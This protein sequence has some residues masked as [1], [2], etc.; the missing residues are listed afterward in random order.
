M[1]DE[2]TTHLISTDAEL[3]KQSLKIKQA[4][5]NKIPIVS[6]DWLLQSLEKV[7]QQPESDYP[8]SAADASQAGPSQGEKRAAHPDAKDDDQEPEPA[9]KKA[10]AVDGTARPKRGAKKEPEPVKDG[11]AKKDEKKDDKDEKGDEENADKDEEEEEKPAAKKKKKA[12]PAKG[13]AKAKKQTKKDEDEQ[14]N[15]DQEEKEAED[16]PVMK[17][18]IKK[19]KAPV[20]VLSGLSCKLSIHR[21]P[22][23]TAHSTTLQPPIT[24]MSMTRARPGMQPSTRPMLVIP[25]L[26]TRLS[27]GPPLI[28]LDWG[29]QQQVLS[30]PVVGERRQVCQRLCCVCPLGSGWRKWPEPVQNVC[31]PMQL[32][33][34]PLQWC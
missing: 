29:Q 6:I 17:T 28:D 15:D 4:Q 1:V 33:T 31:C 8:V 32:L 12:A 18:V 7:A 23:G 11:G 10:K 3:A 19:G 24:S 2:D 34:R 13:K 27:A 5:E 20:D 22:N 30:N 14:K 26:G 21:G 25:C 16:T 9:V